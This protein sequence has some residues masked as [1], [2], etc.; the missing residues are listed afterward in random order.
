MYYAQKTALKKHMTKVHEQKNEFNCTLCESSFVIKHKLRQHMETVHEKKVFTCLHCKA[1]LPSFN[2]LNDHNKKFHEGIRLAKCPK[3]IGTYITVEAL[4]KHI[5]LVHEKETTSYKCSVCKEEFPS[6]R[7]V[8]QH[9]KE[10]HEGAKPNLCTIC[11]S[12]YAT[13]ETLR[14]HIGAIHEGKKKHVCSKCDKPFYRKQDLVKHFEAV[15]EG[16]RDHVCIICNKAFYRKVDMMKHYRLVH[17]KER[18]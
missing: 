16:K 10:V 1:N 6:I 3:C 2:A 8:M 14:D 9:S 13:K 17:E 15:H 4:E 18:P 7:D 11:G 5:Q 12:S